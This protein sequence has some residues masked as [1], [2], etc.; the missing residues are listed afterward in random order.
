MEKLLE[1]DEPMVRRLFG[2]EPFQV[3]HR[4]HEHPLLTFG[5]VADLADALPRQSTGRLRG[6]LPVAWGERDAIPR[7]VDPQPG[8]VVKTIDTSTTR[9]ML[10]EIEQIPEYRELI[11]QCLDQF[12]SCVVDI[13]GPLRRRMVRMFV[14]SPGSVTPAHFDVENNLLLQIRGTKTLSIGKYAT[15][16]D[17]RQALEHWWDGGCCENIKTLPPELVSYEMKPGMGAYMPTLF[18]HWT[19]NGDEP[20]VTLSMFFRTRASER[21]E[22]V[23]AVNARLRR[24]GLSP[25]P[26]GQSVP[27]DRAKVAVMQAARPVVS[28]LQRLRSLAAS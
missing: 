28:R 25:K 18:P 26:P 1:L 10:W 9:L 5:A 8:E 4:V 24:I 23:Q 27:A 22:S 16:E 13:A 20:S 12:Q 21:H 2:H 7:G 19:L 17:E 6:D 14:S 3:R 11:D 15:P